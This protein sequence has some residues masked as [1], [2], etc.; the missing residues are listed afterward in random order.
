MGF[1]QVPRGGRT[2][3]GG[4]DGSGSGYW[5]EEIEEVGECGGV[6]FHC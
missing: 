4:G 3:R 2:G 6:N 1:N 5:K